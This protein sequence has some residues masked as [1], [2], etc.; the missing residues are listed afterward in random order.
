MKSLKWRKLLLPKVSRETNAKDGDSSL[1]V[2]LSSRS[3]G[4]SEL[5]PALRILSQADTIVMN[6]RRKTSIL[7]DEIVVLQAAWRT[8]A[9]RWR[10]M[11]LRKATM[12]VQRRFRGIKFSTGGTNTIDLQLMVMKHKIVC[13]QRYVRGYMVRKSLIRSKLASVQIQSIVRGCA[14]RRRYVKLKAGAVLIQRFARGWRER[15]TFCAVKR[16]VCKI[17]G[18][19]RGYVVRAGIFRIFQAKMTLYRNEIISLWQVCHAPLSFRTKF[20]PALSCTVTFVKI[21]VVESEFKRLWKMIGISINEQSSWGD[22]DIVKLA[23]RIGI[24]SYVYRRCQEL[25]LSICDVDL[26]QEVVTGALAYEEAER[27]QIH[28]R[29]GSKQYEVLSKPM[30]RQFGIPHNAKMKKVALAKVLCKLICLGILCR[31][32]S[33][34]HSAKHAV[35]HY[36]DRTTMRRII[37]IDDVSIVSRIERFSSHFISASLKQEQAAFSVGCE[38]SRVSI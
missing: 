18:H 38:V 23:N 7:L 29:L 35:F 12:C 30:Y 4:A 27:L 2:S 34:I 1:H 33:C 6:A 10:Y 13:I 19:V 24:D 3:L 22:D 25:F 26:Q 11:E 36:R 16:L 14:L 8:Y 37:T 32:C 31:D 9:A 20:W 5:E 21:R 17:Q 28:E 15:I